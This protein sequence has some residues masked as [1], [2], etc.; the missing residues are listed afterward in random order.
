MTLLTWQNVPIPDLASSS[1]EGYRT[2]SHLLENAVRHAQGVTGQIQAQQDAVKAA[3][4]ATAD[5]LLYEQILAE[6]DPDVYAEKRRSGELLSR[7]GDDVSMDMLK[8]ADSREETLRERKDVEDANKYSALITSALQKGH[9]NYENAMEQMIDAPVS[10]KVK[11]DTLKLGKIIHTDEK[12]FPPGHGK[13]GKGGKPKLPSDQAQLLHELTMAPRDPVSEMEVLKKYPP[14]VYLPALKAS[15]DYTGTDYRYLIK[16]DGN[17]AAPDPANMPT[18]GQAIMPPGQMP[19]SGKPGVSG[20]SSTFDSSDHQGSAGTFGF[21]P[22][23]VNKYNIGYGSVMF[24]FAN[25]LQDKATAAGLGAAPGSDGGIVTNGQLISYSDKVRE[26]SKQYTTTEE[27][28][29]YGSTASG[30]GQIVGK[31]RKWLSKALWGDNAQFVPVNAKTEYQQMELLHRKQG[32]DAWKESLSKAESFKDLK[33]FKDVP[34][35]QMQPIISALESGAI[36]DNH[37]GRSDEFHKFAEEK[38]RNLPEGSRIVLK[39]EQ[40]PNSIEEASQRLIEITGAKPEAIGEIERFIREYAKDG[41]SIPEVAGFIAASLEEDGYM[42]NS[43]ITDLLNIDESVLEKHLASIKSDRG[44][45]KTYKK[46]LELDQKLQGRQNDFMKQASYATETLDKARARPG[47]GQQAIEGMSRLVDLS[48]DIERTVL[49][50]EAHM[51]LTPLEQAKRNPPMP[52]RASDQEVDARLN[53][54]LNPKPTKA[55]DLKQSIK[56][57]ATAEKKPVGWGDIYR[58]YG[59]PSDMVQSWM[60]QGMSLNTAIQKAEQWSREESWKK[61]DKKK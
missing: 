47:L 24:R 10:A 3:D 14:E 11:A 29:R 21:R 15:S 1:Q 32:L 22:D 37:V 13:G 30:P 45:A 51:G 4:T 58:T 46:I 39:A 61:A 5:R 43:D 50:A 17:F 54:M 8:F 34:F 44:E 33:Q 31:N 48:E 28:K 12:I 6:K 56:E 53:A 9:V 23:R 59:V 19:S 36:P 55:Q 25:D 49:E 2:A 18:A 60:N 27:A 38:Y 42:S 40:M 26:L 7:L 35:R 41:R 20:K 52:P 16:K 57:A